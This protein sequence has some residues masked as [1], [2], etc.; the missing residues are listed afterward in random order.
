MAG[1]SP[2]VASTEQRCELE[3]LSRSRDRGEADRA[4]AIL[5]TLAGWTS[6]QIAEAFGVREDTVRLWR[7]AFMEGGVAALRKSVAPGPA[8]VKA[9]CALAVAEEVLSGP[10][11]DRP[12]WT[13]PRLADEIEKRSG[14]RISRSRLSVVLRQRGISAGA[15]RATL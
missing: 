13:L 9:A 2:V 1:R 8:P 5:L 15:G 3:A 7:R 14:V 12:N 6:L 10:V 11:A 4:R